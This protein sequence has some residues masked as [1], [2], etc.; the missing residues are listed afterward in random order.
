MIHNKRIDINKD[1]YVMI[2]YHE[3]KET[4]LYT[5]YEVVNNSVFGGYTSFNRDSFLLKVNKIVK[6][7]NKIECQIASI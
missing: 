2:T 1:F 3:G 7:S 6:L 4:R 5:L